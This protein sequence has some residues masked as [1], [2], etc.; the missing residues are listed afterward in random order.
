M[1]ESQYLSV[2]AVTM[3]LKQKSVDKKIRFFA[4]VSF[5]FTSKHIKTS[6]RDTMETDKYLTQDEIS[7]LRKRQNQM[8]LDVWD[9]KQRTLI[10]FIKEKTD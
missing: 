5:R 9:G 1:M 10:D 7:R 4:P 6:W 3:R 8:P 2:G